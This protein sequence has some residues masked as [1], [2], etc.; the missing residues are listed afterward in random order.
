MTT[1]VAM[2]VLRKRTGDGYLF[3]CS[4]SKNTADTVMI[5]MPKMYPDSLLTKLKVAKSS[6]S[7][8]HQFSDIHE[9]PAKRILVR[10]KWPQTRKRN[11]SKAPG[12]KRSSS[13]GCRGLFFHRNVTAPHTDG[14]TSAANNARHR[15]ACN[16]LYS[17]Y[18]LLSSTPKWSAITTIASFTNGATFVLIFR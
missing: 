1:T 6:T 13:S 7:V 2:S 17:T 14:S 5:N 15:T 4:S 10:G 18:S 11:G 3:F 8:C 9:A 16:K 12:A